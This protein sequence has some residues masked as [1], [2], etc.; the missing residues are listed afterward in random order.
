MDHDT[1]VNLK[2]NYVTAQ[3]FT[4]IQIKTFSLDNG[5]TIFSMEKAVIFFLPAS[6]TKVSFSKEERKVK[7]STYT[8]MEIAIKVN[9]SSI[10][11]M[12]KVCILI[13]LPVRNTKASGLTARS[14]E[15]AVIISATEIDTKANGYIISRMERALFTIPLAR[16]MME[17]GS[18]IKFMDSVS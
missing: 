10:R 11:N 9:G 3:A 8:Q 1:T 18:M 16:S 6:A 12:D 15:K 14:L 13:C 17:S 2:E 5:K 7:A 4:I